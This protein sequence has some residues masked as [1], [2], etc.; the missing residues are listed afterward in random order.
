MILSASFAR[1][2]AL[3]LSIAT[4]L[5]TILGGLFAVRFKN[6]LNYIM[7]F[8]AGVLLSVVCFDIL[9]EIIRQVSEYHFSSTPAMIALV[10]G[11]LLFHILE[12]VI[13][14]HHAHEGE[15]A[16][17]SHPEV[18]KL[19]ALALIGHSLM[20]GVGIGLGFQVNSEVGFLVALAVIS[21]DFT[22]GM[23]TVSLMLSHQN[24]TRSARAFLF[25]D[26][27]APMVGVY[28]TILFTVSSFLL[29]LY[30][31]FF[32]GFLLYIGVSD[33]LP[34]AHSQRSSFPLIGLTVL[35]VAFIF[36]IT[37]FA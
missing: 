23:N 25:A 24:S 36:L 37:R 2:P 7:G 30:L 16:V 28:L 8:T 11:F 14:I 17:H 21:H 18:G 35:G 5:S 3:T 9:P 26:A 27:L 22:D 13:V 4:L 19:A 6:K 15:Y 1:M 31:G 10:V 32:A 34:Q 20:D 33:I 29:L 12:K